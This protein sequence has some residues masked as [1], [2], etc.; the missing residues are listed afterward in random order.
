[1]A[2]LDVAAPFGLV[3]RTLL[4][5][6]EDELVTRVAAFAREGLEAGDD[7]VIIAPAERLSAL[8]RELGEAAPVGLIPN[9]LAG[10]RLGTAFDDAR[11]HLAGRAGG[12]R[13]RVAA[14]WDLA[15]RPPS[16]RRA[17][18]RWEAAATAILADRA[19]TVLCCHDGADPEIAAEA[20]ATHPEVWTDGAWRTD[21][22]YRVPRLHLREC[23]SP[24]PPGVPP[25]PLADPWDLAPLRERIRAIGEEA[26]V[27]RGS[28]AD[29]EIAANEVAS[30]ALWHAHGPRDARIGLVDQALVCEVRDAGPGLDPLVAHLPP[31]AREPGGRGLWIA[32]QLAD[33]VQVVPEGAG[34]R[35]R[36]E[37]AVARPRGSSGASERAD[38]LGGEGDLGGGA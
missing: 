35:V 6:G 10:M 32:H 2:A 38:R 30:N 7:T 4:Y 11:R 8:R 36:L 18:M 21:V 1:M 33:V 19:A 12:G 5:A 20:R 14:D 25:M 37:I 34:T 16:E 15:E 24:P 9:H 22:A 17:F 27:E 13:L 3:H 28:L 31:A 23:R 26:G 29:F